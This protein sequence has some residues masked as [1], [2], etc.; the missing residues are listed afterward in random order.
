MDFI[1]QLITSHDGF[2][3]I[4]VIVDRL[5]KRA[6]FIPT[7]TYA[8][9][10]TT[11]EL[12]CKYYMKDHGVPVSIVSDRDSKFT[13]KFWTE[14]M[15]RQGTSLKLSSAFKPQTDGQTEVTNKYINSYA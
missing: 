3:A 11:A 8:T 10:E 15:K 5:T 4:F 13:S 1:T 9:A 14:V 12:F 6:L 7:H 2:D